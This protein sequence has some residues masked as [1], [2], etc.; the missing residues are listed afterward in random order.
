MNKLLTLA[1][2]AMLF[3]T[4]V[5]AAD[6]HG[7]AAADVAVEAAADAAVA[8]PTAEECTA[9]AEAVAGGK[10]DEAQVKV[11]TDCKEAAV[12]AAAEGEKHAE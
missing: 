9:A 12:K 10:A 3:A 5:M 2:A 4:P 8:A 1:A 11:D 7:K 6:D